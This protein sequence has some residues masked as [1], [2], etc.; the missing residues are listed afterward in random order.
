MV[1]DNRLPN[2]TMRDTAVDLSTGCDLSVKAIC[3]SR[4]I[5][6]QSGARKPKVCPIF[7]FC[8]CFLTTAEMAPRVGSVTDVAQTR[9]NSGEGPIERTQNWDRS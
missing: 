4:I 3:G 1:A 6:T 2:L 8:S 9:G 7:D 5:S